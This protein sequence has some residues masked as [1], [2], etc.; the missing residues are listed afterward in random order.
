MRVYG[1]SPEGFLSS[2]K[3]YVDQVWLSG[4]YQ[5][6]IE[7]I[8]SAYGMRFIRFY[9]LIPDLLLEQLVFGCLG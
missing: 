4:V 6:H 7:I 1:M 8:E 5:T 9:D 2:Y 3:W